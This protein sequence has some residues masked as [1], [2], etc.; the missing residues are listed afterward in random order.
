MDC[1]IDLISAGKIKG[2]KTTINGEEEID[3]GSNVFF[4]I[5]EKSRICQGGVKVPGAIYFGQGF[6]NI[7]TVKILMEMK[8][9]PY[10]GKMVKML[11]QSGQTFTLTFG[12]QQITATYQTGL[13]DAIRD[14]YDE[15]IAE[16]EATDFNVIKDDFEEATA[17][18]INEDPTIGMTDDEAIYYDEDNEINVTDEE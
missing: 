9:V 2:K 18:H 17:V 6:S 13:K 3:I 12:G 10:N 7:A 15:I 1:I 4:Y 5:K 14:H 11:S 16:F 8:K